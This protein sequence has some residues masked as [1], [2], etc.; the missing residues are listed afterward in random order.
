MLRRMRICTHPD[1]RQKGAPRLINVL[2]W[3]VRRMTKNEVMTFVTTIR[4]PLLKTE[5]RRDTPSFTHPFSSTY[6][7][8]LLQA[9]SSQLFFNH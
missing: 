2:W 6:H 4:R 9:P 8:H 1:G 7:Y 5:T 3:M